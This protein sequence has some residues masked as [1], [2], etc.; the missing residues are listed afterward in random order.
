MDSIILTDSN[1]RKYLITEDEWNE[2]E[3]IEKFLCP[4]HEV[5]T[6]MSAST[7]PTFS[8]T[9]PLYN[10]LID[11][12]EDII[13]SNNEVNDDEFSEIES[14]IE[15]EKKENWSLS[16]KEAAKLC[17]IKLLK[18]YNKTNDSY[19]ISVILDP[20]LKF[21]YFQTQKWGKELID[22]IQKKLV[23]Y[24]LNNYCNT[25]YIFINYK[26][27]LIIFFRFL[28]VYNTS[29]ASNFEI[30]RET[31]KNKKSIMS[32]VYKRQ[33]IDHT[34]EF[35]IYLSLPL[36]DEDTDPLTWWKSN[37]L[38]FPTLSNMAR[39]YLAIPATSVPSEEIFS[40]G[41]N[42]ITD[43]RNRLAGKT[44][45]VCLCLKSWWTGGLI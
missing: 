10:I 15:N 30:P 4:F 45:R 31:T 43:K 25:I 6:I 19:L 22:D 33:H 3:Q 39:D 28:N 16:I 42:L 34:N 35:K 20:R 44:I 14:N 40:L 12:V 29:Y 18:Y 2:L 5:T 23:Y 21:E 38:Q 36:C 11:H 7:Y 41:K 13:D 9:I 27:L 37:Q 8:V 26:V 17:K 1:L 24:I 32:Q